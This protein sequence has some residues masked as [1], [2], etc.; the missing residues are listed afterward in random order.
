[1]GRV[2]TSKMLKVDATHPGP[3]PKS[4]TSAEG[5]SSVEQSSGSQAAPHQSMD[6]LALVCDQVGKFSSRLRKVSVLASFFQ[7]LSNEDLFLAV[8]FLSEG[9]LAE[10][11]ANQTLF[12]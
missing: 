3:H 6:Q 11:N 12:G 1:M 8:R 7:T 5:A 4:V 9:P 2:P 10:T